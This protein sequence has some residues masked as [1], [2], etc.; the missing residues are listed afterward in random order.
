[1][2]NVKLLEKLVILVN[3]TGALV[4]GQLE[5]LVTLING[6]NALVN[7]QMEIIVLSKWDSALIN[8]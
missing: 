5:K 3:R 4:N 6:I 7:G 8:G 1:L 2:I